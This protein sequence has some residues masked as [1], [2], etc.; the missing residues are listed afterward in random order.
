MSRESKLMLGMLALSTAVLAL[1][2]YYLH[3]QS[4]RLSV[5]TAQNVNKTAQLAS[6]SAENTVE[7]DE[8]GSSA[9]P[10]AT[11]ARK[12][13]S[14]S[15]TLRVRATASPTVTPQATLEE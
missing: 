6:S 10:S 15:A 12:T 3:T 2:Q 13:A 1:F 8:A 11:P 7:K 5:L 14:P 4:V 9:S